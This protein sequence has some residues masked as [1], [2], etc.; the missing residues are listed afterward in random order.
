MFSTFQ[1]TYHSSGIYYLSLVSQYFGVFASSEHQKLQSQIKQNCYYFL[2]GHHLRM[3]LPD[4]QSQRNASEIS[5][6]DPPPQAP[7]VLAYLQIILW[8]LD[9]DFHVIWPRNVG[10]AFFSAITLPI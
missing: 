6:V 2:Y 5:N 3:N 9:L 7:L 8:H 4:V 1:N 10:F